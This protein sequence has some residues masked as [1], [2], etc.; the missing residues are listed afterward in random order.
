M[1]GTKSAVE[2]KE[3]A[4]FVTTIPKPDLIE[5]PNK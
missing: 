5:S 3:R 2:Y 1:P 4:G